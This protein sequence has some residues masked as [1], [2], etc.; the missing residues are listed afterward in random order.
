[1]S[2]DGRP[3]RGILYVLD[4]LRYD[5]VGCNGQPRDITPHIDSVAR[6]GLRCT[7]AHAQ[8]IWTYPSSG[9][10]FTG[11]Y[12]DTHGSQQFDEPLGE[13]QPHLGTVF[14]EPSVTT[15]CFSTTLGVSPARGFGRG[16]DEFYHLGKGDAG[17]R[18][19]ISDRL[20]DT[21][22]PWVDDHASSGFFVVV[23]AMGT[24]HPYLTPSDVDDP[25][26]PLENERHIRGTQDWMR[27]LPRDRVT[28]VE[29]LYESAVEYS[30][31]TFGALLDTL[32][33]N[34]VYDET[35]IVVTADHGDV[36]DEHARLEHAPP[37]RKR[38]M[39]RVLGEARQ[40]YYG[41]FEPT[42]FIGHQGIYP[43]DE[44][45]HV[46]LVVKS[47]ARGP[48]L[49]NSTAELVESVDVLP[50]MCDLAGTHAPEA[51]QGHSILDLLSGSA[52]REFTYSTSELFDGQLRYRS[53]SDG[54]Y[55]LCTKELMGATLSDLRTRRFYES[56]VGNYVDTTEV[57]LDESE[58]AM[59]SS[60]D[61]RESLRTA[62]TEHV[63]E[64]LRWDSAG[65]R[66]S[67]EV[68]EA[69]QEHLRN[70]GYA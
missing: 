35:A 69:T 30:D 41:I 63:A 60:T 11:L 65:E 25:T 57:L 12:P 55:K 52:A 61:T 9:S 66:A 62:L 28:E 56:L 49:P 44:L 14:S 31:R 47:A 1:M 42:A 5:Y 21:L 22:I 70:L 59:L 27:R 2:E 26:R 45:L 43:Y 19:D 46:P 10:I 24:H 53:V 58:T 18:P 6:D 3:F 13:S 4:S 68:D 20:N 64:C 23:W 29:A 40:R 51:V 34:G 39:K 38:V 54:S 15:A 33:D 17:L 16:F 32:V 7:N 67:V 8:A 37:F 50:T 48:D 36:F